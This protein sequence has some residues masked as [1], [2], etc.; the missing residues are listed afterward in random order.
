MGLAILLTLIFS[1]A[2][3]VQIFLNAM[4]A[5]TLIV[6]LIPLIIPLILFG[7]TKKMFDETLKMILG[8]T[9]QLIF[10][11]LYLVFMLVTMDT[12]LFSGPNSLWYVI[13]GAP[14]QAPGF[15]LTDYCE[16]NHVFVDELKLDWLMDLNP[17]PPEDGSKPGGN[18]SYTGVMG[19]LPNIGQKALELIASRIK[20]S[21]P[22][23]VVDFQQLSAA[24]GVSSGEMLK[25]LALSF[26]STV[27]IAYILE[28]ILKYIPDL[29]FEIS[30]GVYES[31]NLSLTSFV[32]GQKGAADMLNNLE[33]QMSK[34]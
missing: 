2:R 22:F 15:S 30:G 14:S 4:A 16:A 26:M 1:V 28:G 3:C 9:L 8:F 6:M 34:S 21:V 19:L 5:I 25:N 32:P 11:P 10:L 33:K 17:A 13:A 24:R 23:Q 12:V 29:A 18:S 7:P 20:I 31:V 27:L